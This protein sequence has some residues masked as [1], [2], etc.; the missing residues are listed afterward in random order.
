MNSIRAFIAAE[1]DPPHKQ[2]LS[3]LISRLKKSDA[4]IKW[5]SEN[6]MH[7]TLRFLG[8]IEETKVGEISVALKTVA[9]GFDEFYI[10]LS[11]IDAFPNMVR[12]RVFWVGMD[13]AGALTALYNGIEQELKKINISAALKSGREEKKRAYKAHL[14]LGRVR[15]SKN[16]SNLLTLIGETDFHPQG[17]IKIDK[18]VLF[19]STLTPKGATYTP[20]VTQNLKK[21]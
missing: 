13:N 21:K 5:A 1:I 19:R 18:I 17:E 2:K 20:L 6:Q 4:D 9:D 7:L 12:P 16:L 11:G 14:T 3:E 8:N 10:R 15:S